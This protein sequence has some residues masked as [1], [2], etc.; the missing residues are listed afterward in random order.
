M[1]NL[2]NNQLTDVDISGLREKAPQ[3]ADYYA[4]AQHVY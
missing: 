4:A 1:L 3:A 2:G